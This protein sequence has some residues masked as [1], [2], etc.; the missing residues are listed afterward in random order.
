MATKKNF[1]D[2][3]GNI[4]EEH[5]CAEEDSHGLMCPEDKVKL[6]GIEDG[7]QVNVQANLAQTDPTAD[8]YVKN[9]PTSESILQMF[10]DMGI[11][12][13]VT[14]QD[15]VLYTDAEGQIFIL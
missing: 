9:K 8:D 6:A 2:I 5:L 10:I 14:D 4:I 13:P 7:A 11:M 3:H 15:N 12:I 1:L